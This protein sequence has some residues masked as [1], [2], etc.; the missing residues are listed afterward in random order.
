MGSAT[1]P[2]RVRSTCL[3]ETCPTIQVEVQVLDL[4]EIGK[5]VLHVLFRCLFMDVGADDDPAF[6]GF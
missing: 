2:S 5:Q 3:Y 1:V 4:S 6:D